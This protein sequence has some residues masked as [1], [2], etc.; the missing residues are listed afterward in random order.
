[1]NTLTQQLEFSYRTRSENL[2]R[3]RQ[4]EFDLLVVGGG[5]T[6]AAVARDAASRGLRVALVEKGDFASGTSSA[7]SKLIHGGLR[8]LENM[9]FKLVFEAL[10][11]RALLLKTVPHMVRPLPFYLPV[12]EGDRNGRF[13]LGLGLWLYDLLS[14]FRAPGRH[15]SLSRTQF[16]AEVPFLN[17]TG[18]KGGFRYFDASMWDDVLVIETLRAAHS[19][20]VASANYVEAVAPIWKNDSV[21]GYRVRDREASSREAGEI[22]LRASRTVICA[23]PWTD[24]LGEKLDPQWHPWLSPSKGVHLIFDLK[25]IPVPGALVMSD[26][27]DQRIAFVIPRPDFGAGVVI[28]GTTDGPSDPHPEK[29]EVKADDVEYLMKLLHRYFP[30]LHITHDDI[31][32]AYVGVRPLVGHPKT[33]SRK[34]VKKALPGSVA[35][36]SSSVPSVSLQKV[37]REHFIGE[38]PGGTLIVAGGKYTTHRTMAEE[39]VDV[40]IG[41]WRRDTQTG[42]GIPMRPELFASLRAPQTLTA[43]NPRATFAAAEE[44]CEKAHRRGVEIPRELLER[45]GAEALDVLEVNASG[46]S[47][48][49]GVQGA[50]TGP[51]GFPLLEAQLRYLMR[52]GMVIHLEDFVFRRIAL[53]TALRDHGASW[54]ERLARVWAEEHGLSGVE[55]ESQAS[56]ECVRLNAEI[57]RRDAWR[58]TLKPIK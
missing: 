16:S 27:K 21:I 17:K 29:T 9:E 15:R 8:Y 20:G 25:R 55:L 57:A 52:S 39:I 28:V 12:Y 11:E 51:H 19:L 1:M 43:V 13:I 10:A 58:S 45:F 31:L 33:Y 49:S 38:G 4:E 46:G 35:K 41:N 24:L 22:D 36:E 6:G 53:F 7:S 32:S 34:A 40:V 42:V 44:A 3:Y 18:L 48:S 37:S 30:D 54:F 56:V 2:R 23:G 5:I 14:L 47:V 26:S 50:E